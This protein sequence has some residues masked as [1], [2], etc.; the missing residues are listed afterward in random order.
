M[1]LMHGLACGAGHEAGQPSKSCRL[2]LPSPLNGERIPRDDSRIE[3]L[4]RRDAGF[5]RDAESVSPSPRGEWC[6]V[7]VRPGVRASFLSHHLRFMESLDLQNWMPIGAMN[8]GSPQARSADS[9]SAVSPTGSRQG[10]AWQ[11]ELGVSLVLGAW[12]LELLQLEVHGKALRGGG[13]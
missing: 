9:L 2:W 13:W 1:L 10:P 4:N 5:R 6:L 11:L 7:E 12:I 8:P 3:P